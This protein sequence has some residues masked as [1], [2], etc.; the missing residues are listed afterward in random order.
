MHVVAKLSPLR[1]TLW[2][3]THTI[4]VLQDKRDGLIAGDSIVA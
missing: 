2:H 3:S 1:T 4:K